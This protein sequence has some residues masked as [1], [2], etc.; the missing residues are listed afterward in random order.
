[1]NPWFCCSLR[2]LR[3]PAAAKST[4]FPGRR[5]IIRVRWEMLSLEFFIDPENCAASDS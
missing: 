2:S 5:P 3:D 1:V 4:A